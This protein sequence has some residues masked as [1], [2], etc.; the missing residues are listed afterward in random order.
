MG[1]FIF[2]KFVFLEVL[3]FVLGEYIEIGFIGV[4]AVILF[5]TILTNLTKIIY[6]RLGNKTK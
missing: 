3:N 1:N 6:F 2:L 4:I 5:A